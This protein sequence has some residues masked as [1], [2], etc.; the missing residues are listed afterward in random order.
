MPLR[1]TYDEEG[2]DDC[3][4][5]FPPAEASV[6]LSCRLDADGNAEHCDLTNPGPAA[7]RSEPLFQCMVTHMNWRFSNGFSTEGLIL[8]I[9][10]EVDP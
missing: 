6:H 9:P 2:F 10:F 3:R 4:G 5:R 1:A 8:P 7:E